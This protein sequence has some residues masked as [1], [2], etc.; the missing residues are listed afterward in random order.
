MTDIRRSALALNPE[1]IEWRRHIHKNP[2]TGFGTLKTEA[3]IMEKLSSMGIRNIRQVKPGRG[4]SAL[5]TGEL[6]GKVLGIRADIDALNM[7]EES[8]LPFAST[9]SY[10]HA[11]GHDAHAAILL[12][13]AKILVENISRL[14]G[15]VKMIFQPSEET[16]E[17]APAMIEDGVLNNPMLEGII[18]LHTGNLW[19]GLSSGQI[20]YRFGAL[21]AGSDW[22][23]I[24][25]EGKG[26]HGA[27]PHLAVDPIAMACQAVS[28]IQTIVSREVSPLDS[29]VVTVG[30]INGGTAPNIIAPTCVIGG[31]LRSL[32]PGTRAM[33]I[34]RIREICENLARAMRGRATVDFTFGPPP[35]VNDTE[36]TGKLIRSA[37][38]ILGEDSVAEVPEPTMGAEDMAFFL[39]K[40]PETFFF[41][42]ADLGGNRDF[43]HHHPKF[44]LNEEVF[45]IGAAVLADFAMTWQ[46]G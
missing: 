34:E 33:L 4:I 45:W 38:R 10:M 35:L 9:N 42:P 29:A 19:K 15:A 22:F 11:C 41:L 23:R 28:A 46:E 7:K 27:T 17:G 26:G 20:G 31:T 24:T 3:F 36:M 1:I 8:G 25:F 6:P 16:G 12:G 32:D 37:V 30:Q 13:A 40:V 21:L 5:V 14:R 18:G 44:T 43:P 2:E 39:E